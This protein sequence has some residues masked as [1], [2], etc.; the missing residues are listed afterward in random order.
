VITKDE[1]LSELNDCQFKLN[2]DQRVD[3]VSLGR[4]CRVVADKLIKETPEDAADIVAELRVALDLLRIS[5]V[6][7]LKFRK[8]EVSPDIEI[9]IAE[10]KVGVEVR[11][12]RPKD[13]TYRNEQATKDKLF[14]AVKHGH[15]EPYGDPQPVEQEILDMIE[16]KSRR[17]RDA[18][19]DYPWIFLYILSDSPHYVEDYEIISAWGRAVKSV[20]DLTFSGLLF[21]WGH[22][23]GLLLNGRALPPDET[24]NLFSQEYPVINPFS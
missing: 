11:R 18:K 17:C 3:Q 10:D 16:D 14:A 19:S 13:G 15:L 20:S 22:F 2:Q 4:R 9:Q 23:T 12:Y 21:R 1:C 8:L 7:A 6:K 5:S 24:I